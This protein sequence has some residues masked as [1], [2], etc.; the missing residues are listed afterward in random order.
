[1]TVKI[2]N[3]TSKKIM[4]INGKNINPKQTIVLDLEK[5]TTLYSQIKSLEKKG[6]LDLA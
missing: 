2:T 1:M 3:A 4:L 6:A 5:G